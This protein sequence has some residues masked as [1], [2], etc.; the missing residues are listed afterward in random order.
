MHLFHDAKQRLPH[1]SR[2]N[3]RQTWV[4]FLWPYIEQGPLAA[5]NDLTEHFYLPPAT[6]DNGTSLRGLT[7]FALAMY[8]CPSDTLGSDQTSGA[9]QRRRGNY[10]VNWG[11][12]RYGQVE[13]PP[14]LAPPNKAPFS[15]INGNRATPRDTSFAHITDGTSTTLLMSEVLKG[16]APTDDDWRGDIMNDDG[17]FRFHTLLTPN[18]SSPDL[19]SSGWFTPT[20]DPLMPATAAASNQQVAAARSRHTGG[21]NASMC[22]ASVRF[23]R[24]DINL[25]VWMAFGSM[26]GE[27]AEATE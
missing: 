4:F 2:N 16:W 21:V 22:D 9:Y 12:S 19:I 20:G 7:G 24:D 3:P 18:A 25:N 11:N 8:N 15:H 26:D 23:F 17:V 14:N 10:V 27:E 13:T 1:G 6:L 5:R